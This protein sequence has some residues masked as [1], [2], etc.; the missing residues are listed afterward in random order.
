MHNNWFL[1]FTYRFLIWYSASNQAKE[2]E[3]KLIFLEVWYNKLI[4]KET[5][6]DQILRE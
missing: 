3:D 6:W 2:I 4:D 5:P 1:L